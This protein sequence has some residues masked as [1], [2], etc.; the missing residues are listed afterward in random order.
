[1]SQ[2]RCGTIVGPTPPVWS[3]RRM[4]GLLMRIEAWHFPCIHVGKGQQIKHKANRVTMS[5]PRLP[6]LYPFL[7]NGFY[8]VESYVL[9]MRHSPTKSFAS[10][11][12][13]RQ[14]H[15]LGIRQQDKFSQRYGPAL[16]PIPFGSGSKRNPEIADTTL[17]STPVGV[18]KY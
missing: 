1:M 16:E 12:R 9:C 10:R 7:F 14:F 4:I 17:Q 3:E 6:F 2:S 8:S 18:H 13:H 15:N 11:A 5:L